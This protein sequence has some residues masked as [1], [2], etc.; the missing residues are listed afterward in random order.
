MIKQKGA[1]A[2][3]G[4]VIALIAVSMAVVSISATFDEILS[5]KNKQLEI[6]NKQLEL[7]GTGI[8]KFGEDITGFQNEIDSLTE[9]Q[10]SLNDFL[11]NYLEQKYLSP[12]EI[13]SE[14]RNVNSL[15][16]EVGRIQNSFK[17]RIINLYKR[18]KN[19]ELE[20]LLSAKTPNEYIRRNQYLQK[21][22]QNRKKELR[23][24]KS[25]RY[26]LE[27]KRKMLS[28]STSSQRV[29]VEAK[30]NEK[31]RVEEKLNTLVIKKSE[32]ENEISLNR[33]RVSLKEIEINN[34]RNFIRNFE[35]NKQNFKGSKTSRISYSSDSLEQI[36]GNMNPP[37]DIGLI[38]DSFGSNVDNR[39][40]SVF[41]N[42]GLDFSIAAGSKVYAVAG[43]T[44]TLIGETPFYGKTIIITHPNGFRTL[45]SSLNEITVK[46]GS[47]VR[48]NQ[49]IGKSGQNLDGQS[50][51][52]ELWKDRTPLN[53]REWLR[54]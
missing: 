10:A 1:G 54:F 46:P 20:L 15:E 33:A 23:D 12:Q 38:R 5:D 19:Y 50:L 41:Q 43:G 22:A 47:Q 17:S 35:R 45:Y 40:Q 4:F 8:G 28:L 14:T 31:F 2:A 11:K 27:E 49:V 48:L 37:V 32:A 36:K 16:N 51:H 30:R 3:A 13:A 9:V 29:Y 39:T 25:K 53:P 44:V 52:F 24:L 6:L 7:A 26:L 34:L 18:G 42:N 21:F